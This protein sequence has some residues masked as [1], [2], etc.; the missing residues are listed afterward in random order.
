MRSRELLTHKASELELEFTPPLGLLAAFV[1][2]FI[3]TKILR[4]TLKP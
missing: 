1:L 3:L 2:Y 4:L